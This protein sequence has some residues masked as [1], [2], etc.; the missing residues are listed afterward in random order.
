M[1]ERQDRHDRQTEE[2]RFSGLGSSQKV[3]CDDLP[4]ACS[5]FDDDLL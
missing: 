1:G 4:H 5:P 3:D 2:A